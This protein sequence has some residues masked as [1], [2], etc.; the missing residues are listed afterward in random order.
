MLQLRIEG[1]SYLKTYQY[2]AVLKES[3]EKLGV[4]V[5]GPTASVLL[6]SNEKYRILLLIKYQDG[7]EQFKHLLKSNTAYQIYMNHTILWY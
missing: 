6:K 5:L 7:F 2:A 1:T 3:L 4:V